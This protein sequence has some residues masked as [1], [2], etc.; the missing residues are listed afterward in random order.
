[1]ADIILCRW[2]QTA[3]RDGHMQVRERGNRVVVF[4]SAY[5]PRGPEG[6]GRARTLQRQ[7]GSMPVDAVKAGAGVPEGVRTQ[8][9]TDECADVEA[10]L[11]ELRV[12]YR[13]ADRQARLIRLAAEID[14][15]ADAVA[16]DRASS[17]LSPDD[18]GPVYAAIDRLQKSLRRQGVKRLPKGKQGGARQA[19]PTPAGQVDVEEVAPGGDHP[20]AGA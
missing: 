3:K 4:R 2:P 14:E 20:S 10:K 17:C 11:E 8:L 12:A 13:T 6:T 19:H 5:E 7:V 9:T 1:M 16:D 15:L 18:A